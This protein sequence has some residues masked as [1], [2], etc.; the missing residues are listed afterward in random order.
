[1]EADSLT[2]GRGTLGLIELVFSSEDSLD[3]VIK[4]VQQS[5][6]KFLHY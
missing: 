4:L 3:A 5:V 1:M 2:A 6:L